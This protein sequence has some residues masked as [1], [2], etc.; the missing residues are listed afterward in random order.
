[1]QR[2][3][4][5]TFSRWV[6]RSALALCIALCAVPWPAEEPKTAPE[7]LETELIR[8]RNAVR[9]ASV[10][11][12][13]NVMGMVPGDGSVPPTPAWKCCANNLK[14]IEASVGEM[15]RILEELDRCYEVEGDEKMLLDVRVA[16]SDL[17]MFAQTVPRFSDAPVRDQALRGLDTMTRA[18]LLFRDTAV[19]LRPCGDIQAGTVQPRKKDA[20]GSGDPN[21][22]SKTDKKK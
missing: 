13:N 22:A 7:P 9:N 12:K 18:F 3:R 1:M 15:R 16:K 19:S 5:G 2:T 17:T 14:R 10:K 11:L 21:S 8:V 4:F 6:R 20:A